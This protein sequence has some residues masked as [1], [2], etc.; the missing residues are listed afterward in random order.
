M[1]SKK[2]GK[3]EKIKK[4]SEYFKK[5]YNLKNKTFQKNQKWKIFTIEE[6]RTILKIFKKSKKSQKIL[7]I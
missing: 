6:N 7:K 4:N 1:K 2:S 3:F 5:I